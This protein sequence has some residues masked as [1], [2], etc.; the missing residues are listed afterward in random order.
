M[1]FV[2]ASGRNNNASARW[3]SLMNMVGFATDAGA[4]RPT[5]VATQVI[6]NSGGKDA[7]TAQ[8][9]AI[10][11]GVTVTTEPVP[12]ARGDDPAGD[13]GRRRG[14]WGDSHTRQRGGTGVPR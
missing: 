7:A 9:L 13:P 10:Y 14:R 2:N 5:Q 11:F 8:W 4:Q 1:T 6:D 3:A 12:T